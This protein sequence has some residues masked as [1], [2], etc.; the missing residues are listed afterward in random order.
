M[1]IF[2]Q[3]CLQVEID[4]HSEGDEAD[5]QEAEPAV[6]E[7]DIVGVQAEGGRSEKKVQKFLEIPPKKECY[8]VLLR[9]VFHDDA[10][11]LRMLFDNHLKKLWLVDN[12]GKAK[13]GQQVLQETPKASSSVHDLKNT[14]LLH[15]NNY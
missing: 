11:L 4:E 8:S 7:E 15:L 5:G 3:T 12:C 6:V 13:G 9:K 1:S 10:V 2:T 14:G